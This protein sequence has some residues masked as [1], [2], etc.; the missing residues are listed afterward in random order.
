VGGDAYTTLPKDNAW[1]F[2]SMINKRRKVR[3]GAPSTGHCYIKIPAQTLKQNVLK[4]LKSVDR[5]C[6]G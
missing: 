2:S 3:A 5:C 4:L 1:R 6:M